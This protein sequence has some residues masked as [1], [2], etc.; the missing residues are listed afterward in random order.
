MTRQ[1]QIQL[2]APNGCAVQGCCIQAQS[3]SSAVEEAV[4]KGALTKRGKFL[5]IVLCEN[6]RLSFRFEVKLT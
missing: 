6:E 3:P 1:Y 2:Y 5:V 4:I